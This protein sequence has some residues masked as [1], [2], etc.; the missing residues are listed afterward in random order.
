MQKQFKT[1]IG[2]NMKQ[3]L[4]RTKQYEQYLGTKM[5]LKMQKQFNMK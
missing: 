2:T 5:P 3:Y 4:M 1:M